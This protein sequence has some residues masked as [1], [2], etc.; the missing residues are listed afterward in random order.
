MK[1]EPAFSPMPVSNGQWRGAGQP[2]H[3]GAGL[4]PA[5]IL[6]EFANNFDYFRTPGSPFVSRDSLEHAGNRPMSGDTYH[7]RMTMLAREITRNPE[8][9]NVLDGI[10]NG[11]EQDGLISPGDVQETMALYAAQNVFSNS[12]GMQTGLG[13]MFGGMRQLRMNQDYFAPQPSY[14]GGAYGGQAPRSEFRPYANDSKEDFSNK[15]LAR[16][17]SLEDPNKPGFITDKSLSSV[18]GGYHLDGRPATQDE[19]EIAQEM[20]SRGDQFKQLDQGRSGKLDGAFSRDDLGDASNKFRA[21]SDHDLVQVIKDNFRQYT[22]GANDGYVNVNELKEAAGVIPSDRT[23]NPDAREA[24]AEMLLR[25]G[26][27]RELDIGISDSGRGVED[28]R[29]DIHNLDYMLRNTK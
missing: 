19:M 1:N 15:V 28:G 7:D 12:R 2:A 8:M 21:V 13:S 16:F 24:A 3:S 4:P 20:L 6:G 5:R 9:A 10:T 14:T 17:G 27:L 29:F 18:A 25:P 11:G 26:L 23:F 22:A